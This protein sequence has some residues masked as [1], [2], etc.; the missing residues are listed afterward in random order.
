MEAAVFGIPVITAGTGRYDGRGFTLDSTTADEYLR[1]LSALESVP[2]LTPEQQELA[3]R[4]AY[5]VLFCRPVKLRSV[6][7]S[8]ERDA[9]AT[10]AVTIRCLHREDWLRSPDMQE[11]AHW[12][13]DGK[14]EDMLS[15]PMSLSL[16]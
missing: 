7:L 10:Q 16:S 15:L 3:E 4:F 12:I 1:R 11:L 13:A 6:S 2:R 9:V 5:G 14:E 8:Y